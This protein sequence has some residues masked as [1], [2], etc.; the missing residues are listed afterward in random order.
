MHLCLFVCVWVCVCVCEPVHV[1]VCTCVRVGV[2]L[3]PSLCGT[4]IKRDKKQ[5]E[6]P[7]ADILSPSPLRSVQTHKGTGRCDGPH[8]KANRHTT[9][10]GLATMVGDSQGRGVDGKVTE[11]LEDILRKVKTMFLS[12]GAVVC[13]R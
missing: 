3:T 2:L 5:L 9:T 8:R 13:V 7:G 11:D 12:R 10:K 4:T 6:V 1:R